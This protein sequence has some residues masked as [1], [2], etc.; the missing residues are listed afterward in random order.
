MMPRDR[1]DFT[2]GQRDPEMDLATFRGSMADV[3][4]AN[5]SLGDKPL[6]VL[7]HGKEPPRPDWLSEDTYGHC[8]Q[9]QRDLQ[10][11]LARLSSN[12]AQ[13]V[14]EN[15]GHFIQEDAPGLVVA[16]VREAVEAVRQRG[17]VS[18]SKL[19]PLAREGRP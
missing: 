16:A 4:R 2:A 8:V 7:T 15:S 14:A 3:R 13:V 12:S 9:L 17:R 6:I 19:I 18:A 1:A 11:N 10:A 5:R